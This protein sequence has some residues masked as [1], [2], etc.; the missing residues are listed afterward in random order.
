MQLYFYSK[1]IGIKILIKY[2]KKNSN[3]V[4]NKYR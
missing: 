2:R 1:D 3:Y 4:N